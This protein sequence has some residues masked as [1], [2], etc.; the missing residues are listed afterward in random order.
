MLNTQGIPVISGTT[1]GA[2]ILR[3]PNGPVPFIYPQI[4]VIYGGNTSSLIPVWVDMLQAGTPLV[5]FLIFGTSKAF[6]DALMFWRW[7]NPILATSMCC[8]RRSPV[9]PRESNA[10]GEVVDHESVVSGDCILDIRQETK[11]ARDISRRAGWEGRHAVSWTLW[12]IGEGAEEL[13][14][15]GEVIGVKQAVRVKTWR[16][17]WELDSCGLTV[18]SATVMHAAA[19]HWAQCEMERESGGAK[20]D[21][22]VEQQ[23]RVETLLKS[24]SSG[25]AHV[26]KAAGFPVKAY[27]HDQLHSAF[28]AIKKHW[29]DADVRVGLRNRIRRLERLLGATSEEIQEVVNVNV[30]GAFAFARE[31]ILSFKDLH[32]YFPFLTSAGKRGML[33]FTGVT[34]A[35][36][37]NKTTSSFA[38]SKFGIPALSQ[39]LNK[40]FGKQDIHVAHSVIDGQIFTDMLKAR[41]D[42]AWAQDEAVRLNPSSIANAYLYLANQDR[43]AWTWEL[44]LR[45]AHENW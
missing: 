28:D 21:Q 36:R 19:R 38:A 22:A 2:T 42:E 15:G 32:T 35:L 37:G 1:Q 8:R 5:A 44:D 6:L 13:K 27:T 18:A 29:P 3:D 4:S 7:F 39:S 23:S 9:T 24:Q 31:T 45:P 12:E 30:V 16:M 40:K 14:S 41:S 33:L 17:Q 34:A 10:G 25:R 11:G 26:T 43:S 20:G